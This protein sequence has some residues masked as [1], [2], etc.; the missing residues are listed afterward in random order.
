[1]ETRPSLPGNERAEEEQLPPPEPVREQS[2]E[3]TDETFTANDTTR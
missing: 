1:M 2:L 3:G